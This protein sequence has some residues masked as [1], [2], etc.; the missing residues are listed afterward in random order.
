MD[1]SKLS[2]LIEKSAQGDEEAFELLLKEI[3]PVL[4]RD[5]G[6]Y[7]SNQHDIDDVIQET[8]WKIW[9]SIDKVSAK[10]EPLAFFRKIAYNTLMSFYRKRKKQEI[11]IS[12]EEFMSIASSNKT[13]E[14]YEEEHIQLHSQLY[15]LLDQLPPRY[16]KAIT[17]KYIEEK[18]YEEIAKAMNISYGAAR[19][20]VS[21]GLKKLKKLAGDN[22]ERSPNK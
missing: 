10:R 5:I 21:R 19:Q 9:S 18:D 3:I 22:N 7:L 6:R 20:L 12:P 2:K 17:M 1:S 4:Y 14:K 16:K 8:I 13:E 11:Y 15:K